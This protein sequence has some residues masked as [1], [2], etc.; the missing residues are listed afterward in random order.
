M[1]F[2]VSWLFAKPVR[3]GA[4]ILALNGCFKRCCLELHLW[5]FYIQ[6]IVKSFFEITTL[7]ISTPMYIKQSMQALALIKT[8]L[9]T[10]I[11]TT[12]MVS[13]MVAAISANQSLLAALGQLEKAVYL[14]FLFMSHTSFW[15]DG[16]STQQHTWSTTYK[17]EYFNYRNFNLSCERYVNL[18]LFMYDY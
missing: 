3:W 1:L 15:L 18:E 13:K 10:I 4:Q 17:Y 8:V 6:K 16:I 9:T 11:V 12:L 14:A 2:K 5:G 7:T